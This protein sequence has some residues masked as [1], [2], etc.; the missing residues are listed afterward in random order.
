MVNVKKINLNNFEELQ[1]QAKIIIVFDFFKQAFELSQKLEKEIKKNQA[2]QASQYYDILY[3][4]K[5]I[6][7]PKLKDGEV[8][9][10][11]ASHFMIIFKISG[12]DIWRKLKSKI[13][14]DIFY[15]DRN[16]FKNKIKKILLDNEEII[17]SKRILVNQKIVNPNI[18]NWL[19]DYNINVGSE[20][21]NKEEQIQYF[22]YS[23]NIKKIDNPEEKN[24]LKILFKIYEKLKISS[25]TAAG[26]EEDIYTE[27]ESGNVGVLS[28]GIFTKIDDRTGK[29][30][31][32]MRKII[33]GEP[34]D[35]KDKFA[36]QPIGEEDKKVGEEDLKTSVQKIIR[37]KQAQKITEKIADNKTSEPVEVKTLKQEK[38]IK[39]SDVLFDKSDD[40]E[41]EKLKTET[42]E[43]KN[44]SG[45]QADDLS[46]ESEQIIKKLNLQMNSFLA[47]RFKNIIISFLKGIR[48]KIGLKEVLRRSTE[49]GGMGMNSQEIDKILKEIQDQKEK[50]KN[51]PTIVESQKFVKSVKSKVYKA[52]KV[53]SQESGI[54]NQE[55]RIKEKKNIG[56]LV[57]KK[58]NFLKNNVA[59]EKIAP[60]PPIVVENKE[61]NKKDESP[62]PKV[63][64][65]EGVESQKFKVESQNEVEKMSQEKM[66]DRRNVLSEIE[67]SKAY[68][69]Q[70][71]RIENNGETGKKQGFFGKLF[72]NKK[73]ESQKSI[74]SIKSIKSK[75]HKVE[76]KEKEMVQEEK[77]EKN[78]D[79]LNNEKPKLVG[80]IEELK[81]LS[82]EDFRNWSKDPMKAIKKIE[83]KIDVAGEKFL[84]KRIL[85]IKA[86]KKSEIN[87]L[88]LEIL[89]DGL[90]KHK[91]IEEI[92]EERKKER[93]TVLS[94]D[95]FE[96][97]MELNKRL[98]F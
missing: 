74:K 8:A 93:N 39:A 15:D 55:L 45:A 42:D 65:A 87:K 69:E 38:E 64:N 95:E 59:I 72:G 63:E 97:I 1:S 98:R 96:A 79:Y 29:Q 3:K 9:E 51:K 71:Q 66:R 78:L 57:N 20:F 28:E 19:R 24:R 52:H 83:E 27:D 76:S 82:I 56:L 22:T 5:W 61:E 94:K 54:K 60:P 92:I 13:I 73:V 35:E 11:F 77:Q 50:I 34:I 53:E 62:K 25:S 84:E 26:I 36:I 68:S 2:M 14:N 81:Y 37:I 16:N 86:W 4:L 49:N 32:L 70:N 10:L 18:A 7:L 80:P 46:L 48:D 17:T 41:I 67:K 58:D 33:S 88:Y 31:K 21:I 30:I 47:A 90:I 89:N 12:F 43:L 40:K 6:A 85:G 91:Q 44:S 75:V 23:E